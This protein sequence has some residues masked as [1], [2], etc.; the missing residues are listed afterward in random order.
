MN[1]NNNSD[2]DIKELSYD[3]ILS[4][5]GMGKYQLKIYLI[6]GLIGITEGS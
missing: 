2:S 5:I 4:R 3:A 1:V 6:F